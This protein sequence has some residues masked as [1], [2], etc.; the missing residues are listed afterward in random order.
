MMATQKD[1]EKALNSRMVEYTGAYPIDVAYPN[2]SYDP[3]EGTSYLQVDYLHGETSQVELGT[4]SADRGVGILQITINTES[5]LG[6]A[7]ASTIITQL[8]EY[9]KR[10]TVASY[11]GLN[12]RITQFYIGASNS[13]GDWYREIVSI[14][15]R[16][17]MLNDE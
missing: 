5:S 14:V 6:T 15:F 2:V 11:N 7:T 16:S 3:N 17:D 9:F 8:K 12:V 10:G 1:I 13:D 4:E